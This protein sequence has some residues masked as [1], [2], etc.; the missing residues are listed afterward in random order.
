MYL[1]HKDHF[2]AHLFTPRWG[3]RWSDTK[4]KRVIVDFFITYKR[5]VNVKNQPATTCL[6]PSMLQDSI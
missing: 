4:L 6:Q 1:L 2:L 5:T 3:K